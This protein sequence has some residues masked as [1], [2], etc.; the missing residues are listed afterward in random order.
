M[1]SKLDKRILLGIVL[2]YFIVFASFTALRHYT[3]QTQ[4]WDM[5]AFVQTFWNT[6]HGKIMF[7]NLEEVPNHLGLHWTPFLFLLI[8]GYLLFPSPYYLL[9]I[10]TLALALGAI[11]L[12]LLAKKHLGKTNWAALATGAY[13]LYPSLHWVNTFDF[14]ELT[15]LAPILITAIYFFEEKKWLWAGIF[16]ALS[17][18]VREDAIPVVIFVALY[19]LFRS[20]LGFEKSWWKL[21]RKIAVLI[22]V[23][24]IIYLALTLAVFMPAFT[25][26]KLIRFDRYQHLGETPGEAIKNAV[27]QPMLIAETIF[28]P[29]KIRYFLWL[30]APLAFLPL[31]SGW[32]LAMLLPGL[33]EN[34]LTNFSFQ[35]SGNY[36]YD[37]VIIPVMLVCLIYGLK[38]ILSR[39]PA[40][41]K[42]VFWIL[43]GAILIAFLVRSP[44][45]PINSPWQLL[46]NRPEWK[47]YRELV[48]MVPPE[49]TV[50]AYT[51]LVPHLSHR[52]HAYMIGREKQ[53]VEVVIADTAD[54]F[55][56]PSQEAFQKYIDSSISKT[57]NLPED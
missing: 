49:A 48:K 26:G 24:G 38:N 42:V 11:P 50:A 47:A 12:Y 9:I 14:H 6:I 20:K 55:G 53:P 25:E 51:N 39:W 30:F 21:D 1:L 29:E 27:A 4:T 36:Q 17:A 37:S 19:F 13:L 54:I 34:L 18:A 33:A 5:A 15:F 35:F 44:I 16:F 7:N 46:Q 43:A 52:E 10:Q 45:S 2:A 40:K 31:A 56:F 28:T 23:T 22:A 3:F 57:T 32:A 8:P 41:E